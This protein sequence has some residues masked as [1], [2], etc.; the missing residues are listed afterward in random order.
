MRYRDTYLFDGYLVVK[1]IKLNQFLVLIDK[2][3]ASAL[4]QLDFVNEPDI[5]E[6]YIAIA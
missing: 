4:I 6:G 5:S 3:G 1:Y 2:I